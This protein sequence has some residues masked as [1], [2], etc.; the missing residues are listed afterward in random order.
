MNYILDDNNISNDNGSHNALAISKLKQIGSRARFVAIIQLIFFGFMILFFLYLLL[1]GTFI[2][3]AVSDE[4]STGQL[5]SNFPFDINNL[6]SLWTPILTLLLIFFSSYFLA[7]IKLANY[8]TKI[9]EFTQTGNPKTFEMAL[10]NRKTYFTIIGIIS[11]LGTA[12]SIFML[13]KFQ[14]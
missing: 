13:I 6:D 3:A 1:A 14:F 2:L 9:I 8:G 5:N 4:L 12:Y 10:R 7:A 11:L